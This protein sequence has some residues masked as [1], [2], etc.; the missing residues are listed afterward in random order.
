MRWNR[1]EVKRN[2]FEA[3]QGEESPKEPIPILPY[4]HF[5]VINPPRYMDPGFVEALENGSLIL[6]DDL[7]FECLGES[8]DYLAYEPF[9]NRIREWQAVLTDGSKE[10]PKQAKS[11]L[12]KVGKVLASVRARG[13]PA[14]K[15]S[16]SFLIEHARLLSRLQPFCAQSKGLRRLA[17][18]ESFGSQFPDLSDFADFAVQ[19]RGARTLCDNLMAKIYDISPREVKYRLKDQ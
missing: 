10:N 13:R 5:E 1:L 6:T 4:S 12:E 15:V 14:K 8:P 9:R 7:F 16:R 11:N 18:M 3:S 17:W 2:I 19:Y